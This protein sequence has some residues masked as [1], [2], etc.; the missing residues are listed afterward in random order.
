MAVAL[1][2][3]EPSSRDAGAGDEVVEPPAPCEP[4]N[5]GIEICDGIDNDCDGDADERGDLV[6]TFQVGDACGTDVGECRRGARECVDG[7]RRCVGG[8][9]PVPE[10][11]NARD[12]DCDGQTDESVDL[13]RTREIGVSCGSGEGACD[14]GW[15][16][17][18]EGR[19]VCDGE[20]LPAAEAC[21]GVDDD[22]DGET[23]E[24][25]DLEVAG[26]VGYACGS[27]L[28]ACLPGVSVCV[29]GETRC[30]GESAPGGEVCDGIDNDCDG[31]TDEWVDL[32]AAGLAGVRCG[33][34]TGACEPGIA[35]CVRGVTVCDGQ[36]GPVEELCDEL[37]NDCDGEI[38]EEYPTLGDGCGTGA[39][40][41]GVLRCDLDD[42][43]GSA[44]ACST[45]A[46]A[47]EEVC[48]GRD[49]DCDGETDEGVLNA[50]GACGEVPAE[51]CNERDDDCDGETDEGVLNACGAC[52]EVPEEVCNGEDDDCDG[53][54]DE[55]L[56][57]CLDG[58]YV[59]DP[60]FASAEV[61]DGLDNDCDGEVDEEP[62]GAGEECRRVADGCRRV[63]VVACVDAHL[64]CVEDPDGS[65]ECEALNT[66][67]E[68]NNDAN[69]C[70]PILS[71]DHTV[72]GRINPDQDRDWF[73]FQMEGRRTVE[74][75]ISA[76]DRG[77]AL[78]SYLW[79]WQISPR[80]LITRNDDD[81]GLD[82]FIRYT[83]TGAGQYAIEVGAYNE[84]GCADCTYRLTV[85]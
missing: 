57:H 79:L 11:C 17:C 85:R 31:A 32:A 81:D 77:S 47:S 62:E 41:G 69:H 28:G 27:G 20:V 6:A 68:P 16:A 10:T 80:R 19:L 75:D 34:G 74:F 49:D 59:C 60:E 30:E 33:T 18:L 66:E 21:N 39:C 24:V 22:C 54:I 48:N 45:A 51:T 71:R 46:E 83:F 58:Q 5:R 36:V 15:V 43:D 1:A 82:S 84:N 70:N 64:Q 44:V 76:R 61:C 72:S 23:D 42:P 78:D 35:Q 29:A 56:H 2:G 14:T 55:G 37:D 26:L 8:V 52:G 53:E 9:E 73:C 65:N 3:C 40:A 4:T 25:A 7:E 50:C 12:D 13:R 67:R 38:D 63:G